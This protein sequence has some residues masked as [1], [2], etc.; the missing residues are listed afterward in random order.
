MEAHPLRFMCQGLRQSPK[1]LKA[2]PKPKHNITKLVSH[3]DTD[4]NE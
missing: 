2:V 3:R 4:N 1:L